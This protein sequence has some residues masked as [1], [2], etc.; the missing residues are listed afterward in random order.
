VAGIVSR[1]HSRVLAEATGDASSVP[2]ELSRNIVWHSRPYTWDAAATPNLQPAFPPY[3]DL[4][5]GLV[6]SPGC[7]LS[8]NG[9]PGFVSPYVNSL[10]SAAAADEGGNFV[11]VLFTPL[12][13]TGDYTATGTAAGAGP[14]D[15][16]GT[17]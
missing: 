11:Q 4:S 9:D 12:G 3:S 17:P 13:R 16:V 14:S 2:A 8:T 15:A 7:F 10:V 5:S 1:P 6:C